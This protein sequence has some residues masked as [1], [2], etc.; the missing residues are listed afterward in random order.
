M[1][2]AL[3]LMAMC[4]LAVAPVSAAAGGNDAATSKK[5]TAEKKRATDERR[6]L[7]G[8]ATTTIPR[9]LEMIVCEDLCAAFGVCCKPPRQ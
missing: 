2:R 1:I 5:Y 6:S 8:A 7:K 9:D 3:A 4:A